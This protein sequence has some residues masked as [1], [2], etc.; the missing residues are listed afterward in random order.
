MTACILLCAISAIAATVSYPVPYVRF[1]VYNTTRNM[2]ISGTAGGSP[3]NSWI[4]NGVK[5]EDWEIVYVEKGVYEF[6]NAST[7]LYITAD[8][9]TA[10][11]SALTGD[12]TQKWN[13]TGTD[14]DFLG[15]Y[16]YYK[17]TNASTGKALT[18]NVKGNSVTLSAFSGDSLQK[19]R[20]DL[21]GLQGFAGPAKVSEGIKAGVIGGLLGKTVF[22]TTVADLR[23]YLASADPL[24][25]VIAADIDCHAQSSIRVQSNKTLI[26]SYS[27]SKLGDAQLQSNEYGY[28]SSKA[29]SVYGAPSDN[30]IFLNIT[31]AA[32]INKDKILLSIY[33]GKNVWI[34]HCTFYSTLSNSVNEVGKFVWVNT[35]YN[36]SDK[37]RSPDF[38]TVSYNIFKNRYWCLVY[39]TQNGI[40]AEDRTSVMFNIFDSDVRRTPEIGNGTLHDYSNYLVRNNTSVE[41]DP[42]ASIIVDTGAQGYAE[43]NRFEGY[44][45]ESSGYWDFEYI[46]NNATGF[47]DT[48]SYSNRS[49]SGSSSVTPT[50]WASYSTYTTAAASTWKPSSVYGYSKTKAYDASGKVDTKAF[51]LAYSGSRTTAGLVYITDNAAS[52]YVSTTVASPFL[53]SIA[54]TL[55]ETGT[56]SFSGARAPLAL[57]I[58]QNAKTLRISGNAVIHSVNLF[59]I[60]GKRLL[61]STPEASA[62][63]ISTRSLPRGIYAMQ[64]N[65]DIG[66]Q[67]I[68]VQLK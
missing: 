50:E 1:G 35:P 16:L 8:G 18:F 38:V 56:T 6:K 37:K 49:A 27:A 3:L 60:R 62:V 19:W 25:I 42:L 65:T 32:E 41:N 54:V 15:N 26:G 51:C 47:T 11:I 46:V 30:M 24:T 10:R 48:G 40:T 63:E 21:N 68:I 23:T 64:A 13:I 44:R 12:G 34:D 20:F 67:K 31:F 36:A 33:S 57:N 59:D 5:N 4:T 2:N 52:G 28:N 58:S 14:K 9:D 55:S 43:S 39:G 66:S 29:D 61:C 22:V 45:Q 53:K 17:I 7:G